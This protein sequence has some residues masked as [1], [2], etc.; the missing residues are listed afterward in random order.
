MSYIFCKI[1]GLIKKMIM[2]APTPSSP[3]RLP[4]TRSQVVDGLKQAKALRAKLLLELTASDK[5]QQLKNFTEITRSIKSGPD[6]ENG[7]ATKE[8]LIESKENRRGF[9]LS[10]RT[11]GQK[12]E[13]G[14]ETRNGKS[15]RWF[16]YNSEDYKISVRNDLDK[17]FKSLSLLIDNAQIMNDLDK[18]RNTKN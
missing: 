11:N 8:L 2:I 7:I 13:L 4:R 10:F 16:D 14:F 3:N 9:K 1:K 15:K 5:Y 18:N 6:V 12:K 17:V